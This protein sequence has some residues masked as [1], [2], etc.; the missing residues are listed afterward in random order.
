MGVGTVAGEL[1]LLEE[2]NA[3]TEGRLRLRLDANRAWNECAAR[4]FL[5]WVASLPIDAVEEPLARPTLQQLRDLQRE[6]P[7]AVAL[8]ESLPQFGVDALLTA[9]AVRR[10]VV[11]PARIGRVVATRDRVNRARDAGLEVVLT[12]V[13]DSARAVVPASM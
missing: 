8:D 10:L 2:V 1:E 7:Y 6:L 11:K 13:L 12:S 3:A 9:G 5:T 4:H